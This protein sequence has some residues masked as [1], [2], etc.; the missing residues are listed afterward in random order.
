MSTLPS[1]TPGAVQRS[2]LLR[3][4]SELSA[5]MHSGNGRGSAGAATSIAKFQTFTELMLASD[6]HVA[7]PGIQHLYTQTSAL[8][9]TSGAG[10]AP[11]FR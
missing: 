6:G 9:V 8:S 11:L 7:A 5:T 2:N 10:G 3:E 1:L 4:L